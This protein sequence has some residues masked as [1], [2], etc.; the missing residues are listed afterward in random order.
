MGLKREFPRGIEDCKELVNLDLS[1]NE[2][3][4]SIPLSVGNCS[5]L[6]VLKLDNNKLTGQISQQLKQLKNLRIFSVANNLLSGLVPEFVNINIMRESY[7]NNSGLCGGPLEYCK[8]HRWEFEVSFKSG[9]MVGFVFTATL[10]TPFF[11]YYI[12]LRVGLKKNNHNK[13]M[14]TT[15]M[16][17]LLSRRKNRTK[18]CSVSQ[19]PTEARQQELSKEFLIVE[20]MV[21]KI[22]FT[23][24]SK[25]TN[26]FSASNV[27][28]S[29]KMGTMYKAILLDGT[30][31]AVKRINTSQH[32]EDQLL[33][34]LMTLDTFILSHGTQSDINCLKSIRDSL[35]DPLN[36]LKTSWTF[37]N[38]AEGSI[39]NYVGVTCLNPTQNRVCGIVLANMGLKGE[40]P[41]GIEDCRELVNLD[42]SG[43]EISGSI[44]SG[45]ENCSYLEVLKLDNNKLTGQISQQLSQLKNLRIFSVANNLLSGP[46]PEFVN[47]NITRESYVNNSGLCGGPLE[48]CKKHRWE[49]EV[50]FRSGF[51]VGFVFTATL[52]TPFFM[53]YIN[54]RVGLKKKNHNKTMSATKM[55]ALLARRKNRTKPCSVSQ[56]PTEARPQELSKEGVK[57]D[58]KS[59]STF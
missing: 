6:E 31:L 49:F 58:Y 42:L 19:I 54:F 57:N 14:S 34:E 55:T 32:H 25:A 27:I 12:N 41:K 29:S 18:P 21:T 36:L 15:K 2:I 46:V 50:S 44:P 33:S 59:K 23:R 45:I 22:S 40:F 8:K 1:G 13:M 20:G 9:F 26:N 24:L 38:L 43:N 39:C 51:V 17:A 28:G 3:S 37:N 10:Y 11:M 5:Y 53:Y 47:I 4:G 7:V 52:Y 30:F 35:E 48:Y 56:I 16:T